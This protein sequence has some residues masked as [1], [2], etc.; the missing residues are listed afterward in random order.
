MNP[1]IGYLVAGGLLLSALSG[2]GSY[3]LGYDHASAEA[4]AAMQAHLR[5]DAEAAEE[6]IIRAR[7]YEQKLEAAQS[8]VASAYEQGK[9]DA[10]AENERVVA[11]LRSGNLR[12][13]NR[14]SGCEA[15]RV[16]DATAAAR[17]LDAAIRDREES[18][19]RIIRAAAEC[20][21]Q[22]RGLQ[23]LLLLERQQETG[24]DDS[25]RR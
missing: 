19:G 24:T 11:D 1:L 5:E 17:E 2:F 15:V 13:Q 20:D 12:L 16:S 8:R 3:K 18:A 23:D 9:R 4:D 6:A 10:E 14:W 21:A 22:V 25:S 7:A